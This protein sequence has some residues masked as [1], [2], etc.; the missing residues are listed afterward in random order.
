MRRDDETTGGRRGTNAVYRLAEPV[1]ARIGRP[2][3][4]AEKASRTVE[5]ARWLESVAY[6][7]V[8][9]IGV[10]QPVIVDGYAVTFW[11]AVSDGNEYA[12]IAQVAE[13]IARLHALTPISTQRIAPL[14]R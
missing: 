9:A 6:P 4:G 11:E 5:V 10:D 1:V 12:T 8:R 14:A 7:A 13:V 2:D 3:A